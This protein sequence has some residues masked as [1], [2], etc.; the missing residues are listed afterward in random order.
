[1]VGLPWT[2]RLIVRVCFMRLP[3]ATKFAETAGM[4]PFTLLA[5]ALICAV[6]LA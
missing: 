6:A 4:S 1:M 2:I 5:T 3:S